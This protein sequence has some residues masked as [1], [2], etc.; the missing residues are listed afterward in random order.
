MP[1]YCVTYD[2]RAPGRNYQALY[3]RIRQY[4]GWAKVTE[5]NWILVTGWTAVQIRDDL[6]QYIDANDRLFVL[7]SGSE[8]AWKNS[9]CQDDWLRSN[10]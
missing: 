4:P 10:L 5:S 3:D 7:R 2:L 6:S 9:I 8:A 1:A